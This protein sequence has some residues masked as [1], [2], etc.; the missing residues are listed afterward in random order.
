MHLVDPI[1]MLTCKVFSRRDKDFGDVLAAWPKI[2]QNLLRE[3]IARNT[4]AFRTLP[5]AVAAAQ[6]NWYVL[7]GEQQLPG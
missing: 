6:H 2:D 3:R 1:D 4:T 5:E 7:T